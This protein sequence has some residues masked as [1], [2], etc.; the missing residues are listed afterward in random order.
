MLLTFITF[1]IVFSLVIFAHEFG[2]FFAAKKAGVK[3]DEFGFGYPPRLFAKKWHGTEY[4]LNWIPFGGFVKLRGLE[5]EARPD[6]PDSFMTKKAWPRFTILVAGVFMNVVLAYVIVS[7]G[8]MIGLPSALS[9]EV[10]NAHIKNLQVQVYEVMADSPAAKAE[11][12]VGDFILAVDGQAITKIEELQ[13]YDA[14]VA[15]DQVI[16]SVKRNGKITEMTSALTVLDE[17]GLKKLGVSLVETGLVSYPFHLAL[18]QGLKTTGNLLWQIIYGIYSIVKSS[19]I[20]H[21]FP[22]EIAGPVGIA[23]LSG[24]VARLGFIYI[25][26]FVVIL[27][28]SLAIMN[29]IPL[30]AFDGGRIL[31]IVIEKI[32]G[33]PVNRRVENTIHMVGFYFLITLLVFVTFRDIGR[34]NLDD[35][36]INF[37][38]NLFR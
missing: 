27:S 20:T 7:L 29:L 18:W 2:H 11:L 32:K 10:K 23:V 34:F 35:G 21:K 12:K 24:Q 6:D 37:F 31:F 15:T 30:P 16:L 25:L 19:F 3:V 26:Q 5:E 8:F 4:S 17:S 22:T 33:R 36:V 14:G 1:I 13:N 28:L 38:K 9:G